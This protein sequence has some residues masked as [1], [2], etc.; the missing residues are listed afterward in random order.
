[1]MVSFLYPL[2]WLGA[3]AVAA[4]L[5]LHLRRRSDRPVVR[6]PAARFLDDHAIADERPLRLRDP[7]LFVLRAAALILLIAAF[8]WPYL[9]QRSS[10]PIQVSRVLV[11][12]NTLSHQAE[13]RFLTARQAAVESV[14][15]AS[16]DTQ[17]AVVEVGRTPRVI[18]EFQDRPDAAVAKLAA[19]EPGFERGSYLAAF[20]QAAALLEMSSGPRRRI[21]LLGDNQESQWTDTEPTLPFL[22]ELEVQ[23]PPTIPAKA[24]NLSVAAPELRRSFQAGVAIVELQVQLARSGDMPA[25]LIIVESNGKEV[26]KRP[27]LFASPESTTTT[28]RVAWPVDERQEVRGSVRARRLAAPPETPA[29]SAVT[30]P[31]LSLEIITGEDALPMD[32]VAWFH[33]PPR[34]EGRVAVIAQSPYLAAALSPEVMLGRWAAVMAEAGAGR[35]ERLKSGDVLLI[36]AR[37]LLESSTKE[38]F[39]HYQRTRR[40]VFLVVDRESTLITDGLKSLGLEF[41]GD[42][43]DA[44]PAPF[45]YIMF[46][47][48]IFQPLR[49]RDFG[50]LLD[51]RVSRYR[52][53]AAP[54]ARVL[55]YSALGDPLLMEIDNGA[56]RV[57]VAA[58][59]WERNATNWPIHPSF[60]PFLDLSLE[61]LREREPWQRQFEPGER[62]LW[63]LDAVG[64]RAAAIN[65]SA[66]TSASN[67]ASTSDTTS[68]TASDSTSDPTRDAV[69]VTDAEGVERYRGPRRGELVDF[70]VPTRPG[71]YD[72]SLDGGRTI[73]RTIAVNP[74]PL[75]SLLTYASGESRVAL[76]RG[77][78]GG[79]L[80]QP[81]GAGAESI[82]SK[83][84]G[85]AP[86][87]A[88]ASASSAADAA[89]AVRKVSGGKNADLDGPVELSA[90]LRQQ[91]WWWLLAGGALLLAVEMVWTSWRVS[92]GTPRRSVFVAKNPAREGA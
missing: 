87:G 61:Y 21:E 26:A 84:L 73:S 83:N 86:A 80:A 63:T 77:T 9:S 14:A 68:D 20:R 3:L 39:E 64:K 22:G 81:G 27:V 38:L 34:E 10:G 33:E 53:F 66:S 19:L 4:P 6:F 43:R 18:V 36:E 32:D 5:W 51:I 91:G 41:G 46:D 89:S 29:P 58:F 23:L 54:N 40:G 88:T 59:G 82:G 49:T 2:C 24:I 42:V 11:I 67:S 52:R 57:V 60:V 37:F 47:H 50:D 72:V 48:P 79:A 12:D 30:P 55:V 28:L 25:A 7:W 8:A 76:W 75:E 17:V 62:C 70:P 13:G 16:P 78:T 45:R 15:K 90:I 92:R 71:L 65:A 1:M 31:D 85:L 44:A 74:S 56:A 69:V 35:D